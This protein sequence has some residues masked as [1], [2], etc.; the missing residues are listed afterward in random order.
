VGFAAVLS[1]AVWNGFPLVFADTGGYL[2]RWSE[3][4]LDIGRSAL[5]GAFLAAGVP[6]RFW[7][8]VAVQAALTVW[9]VALVLRV[10][11]L[12][13]RPVLL[14]SVMVGLS[15]LTSLPWYVGQLM[16]DIFLP[17]AVLAIYLLALPRQALTRREI[18]GLI[19]V[20]GIAI[21]LHMSILALSLVLTLAL[22]LL[23]PVAAR[24]RIAAPR[25]AWPAASLV[26]GLL[27]APVANLAITGTFALT[28]GGTTFLFG[29]LVQDGIVAEYLADHCPDRTL[30]LCQYRNRLPTA[31]DDWLWSYQSPL[32][33]LGWWRAFEPEAGRIIRESLAEHPGRHLLAAGA[34]SVRQLGRFKTGEGMGSA[35]NWHAESVL[36]R[37]APGA[38]APFR[39][40]RQQNDELDFTLINIVQVPLACLAMAA[41]VLFAARRWPPGARPA[42]WLAATCL[43]ALFANAAICG[44]FS[45]PN[46]R[47]QSRIVWLAPFAVMIALLV[48][49]RAGTP[50]LSLRTGI[51]HSPDRAASASMTG[52]AERNRQ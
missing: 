45:N 13:G 20:V 12:G 34:G 6:L 10:N 46:D 5:Y 29:R 43:I 23:K 49:A 33:R 17:L 31:A 26:A 3:R 32:H 50:A 27:L 25:L 37:T 7:P 1:P 15:A 48:R 47:Y 39:A 2:E 21:A 52:E 22:G 4:S 42:G 41:L 51:G 44:V 28:P 40:S 36:L 16:P 9:I 18:A 35:D 30:R 11:G 38:V 14:G 8:N 24:L 19:A